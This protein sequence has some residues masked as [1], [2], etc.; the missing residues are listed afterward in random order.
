MS[1]GHAA[2]K[3]QRSAFPDAYDKWEGMAAQLVNGA[4][5]QQAISA[6]PA[7]Q[8]QF[9]RPVNGGIVSSRY[10]YRIH[11]ITGKR[12]MHD[13]TDIAAPTGTPIM[14]SGSGEVIYAG[15]KG[16][17]GNFTILRHNNGMVS[18]YGHQ[19]RIGVRVG[20]KVS[21]GQ[22]I[23]KIGSTG[24]STG[25]H[26]H[27]MLGQGQ[28]TQGAWQN[29]GDFIPGLRKGGFTLNDGYAKLH[30]S[31]TVLTAPLSA[32]LKSGIEKIDQS[33]SNQY[34]ISVDLSGSYIKEDVDI[35]KAVYAALDKRESKM[36][37]TR[38]I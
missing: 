19:S 27:F 16:G 5:Q 23:G 9:I 24:F 33:S 30:K 32:Q 35:E 3:V 7:T 18:A 17:Y 28:N 2:Q 4:N 10:G 29:P 26:L 38:K 15:S 1:L 37:R 13:G 14:A 12:T 31:E 22:E 25:P 8:T 6:D 11:P 36:G 21:R 34:T 20:D